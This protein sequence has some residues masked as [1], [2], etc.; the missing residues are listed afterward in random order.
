MRVARLIIGA[1]LILYGAFRVYR[2]FQNHG[3][4]DAYLLGGVCIVC[5][6][7]FYARFFPKSQE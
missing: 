5:G 4:F 2:A 6:V 7:V 3:D 1:L